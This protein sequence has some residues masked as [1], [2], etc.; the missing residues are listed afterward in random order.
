MIYF[1]D[2][3]D[4]MRQTY[5]G[6][7]IPFDIEFVSY[8]IARKTGGEIIAYKAVVLADTHKE[9]KKYV[10]TGGAPEKSASQPAHKANQTANLFIPET[11]QI[12]KFHPRLVIS[13]NNE[14]VRY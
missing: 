6:K 3:M 13:F 5:Q 7:P 14:K 11:G 4:K 2:M 8:D 10:K 12:R 1:K 9:A